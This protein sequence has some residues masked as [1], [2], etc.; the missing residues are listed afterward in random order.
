MGDE[1][2]C[3][4]GMLFDQFASMIQ[5]AIH[6]MGAAL[7]PT[8]LIESELKD[9][10]LVA[11]C[12]ESRTSIGAYYFVWPKGEPTYQPRDLFVTWLTKFRDFTGPMDMGL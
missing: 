6:G 1:L 5:A 10:R 8:Y 4:A 12:P 11:L 2:E 9:G 7:I 3:P